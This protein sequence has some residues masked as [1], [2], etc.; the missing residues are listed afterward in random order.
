MRRRVGEKLQTLCFT[1]GIKYG[2]DSYGVV[3][4]AKVR[5]LHQMKDK[6]NPTGYHSIQAILSGTRLKAQ[7]FVHMQDND[8]KHT[9]KLRQ[10]YI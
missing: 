3:T 8:P 9:S 6:L 2:G 1:V 4:F 10:R 7:R 5:N